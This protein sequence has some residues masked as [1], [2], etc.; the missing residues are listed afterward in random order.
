MSLHSHKEGSTPPQ[1][2]QNVIK[3]II[4]YYNVKIRL[5]IPRQWNGEGG[6]VSDLLLI[7]YEKFVNNLSLR[8]N[9]TLTNEYLQ[10]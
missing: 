7:N 3:I 10:D 1:Y 4:N 2:K 9:L 6:W 8:I 5:P